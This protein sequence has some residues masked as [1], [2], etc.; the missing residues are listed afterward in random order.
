MWGEAGVWTRVE[1]GEVGRAAKIWVNGTQRRAL[2]LRPVQT[3]GRESDVEGLEP[4]GSRAVEVKGRGAAPVAGWAVTGSGRYRC[5]GLLT[6]PFKPSAQAR[7]NVFQ[8]FDGGCPC[9]SSWG[10]MEVS[11]LVE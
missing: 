11:V 1:V 3:D 2:G 5:Q 4:G 9:R 10:T 8:V 7:F 6:S